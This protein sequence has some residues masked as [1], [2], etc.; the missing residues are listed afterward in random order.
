MPEL[1]F[2]V[3]E[4]FYPYD[5]DKS[6]VE[7]ANA[8][9]SR[10]ELFTIFFEVAH[11]QIAAILAEEM[12]DVLSDILSGGSADLDRV[13]PKVE[14]LFRDF[15]KSREAELYVPGTPTEASTHREA[16]RPSFIDTGLIMENF[17]VWVE[18]ND[19][20]FGSR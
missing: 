16:D 19:A 20:G 13:G 1:H 2:G 9:E 17:R 14:A 18:D 15:L 10:Y 5:S 11:E 6:T 7:V 3:D 4:E 8:L 12:A